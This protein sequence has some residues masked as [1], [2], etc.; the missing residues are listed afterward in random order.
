MKN[1]MHP[2]EFILWAYMEPLN[3][4]AVELADRLDISPSTLS[5]II[6]GKMDLSYEMAV[7]LS[8]VL[9]R[10]PESWVNLQTAYSLEQAK[11]KIDYAKLKPLT[12]LTKKHVHIEN[13]T[14]VTA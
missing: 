3:I 12:E 1:P 14:E 5:R 8:N 13:D 9:G 2:G 11:M 10:T 4:Q 6:N 7:R